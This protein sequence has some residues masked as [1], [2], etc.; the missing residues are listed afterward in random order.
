MSWCKT[1]FTSALHQALFALD[2]SE[3]TAAVYISVLRYK[4]KRAFVWMERNVNVDTRTTVGC[5]REVG[6]LAAG[7]DKTLRAA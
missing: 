7:N 6:K 2:R 3:Q 1:N 5:C 4:L